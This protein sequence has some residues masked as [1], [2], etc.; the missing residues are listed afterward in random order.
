MGV[1]QSGFNSFVVADIPGLVPGA[2]EGVGLG[3]QFLK[4]LSRVKVLLHIVD[5]S[6]FEAEN[7]IKNINDINAELELFDSDLAQKEQWIV[8]NKNDLDLSKEEMIRKEIKEEFKEQRIFSI[9]A[10]TGKGLKNL[11]SEI[12]TKVFSLD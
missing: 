8:I 6:S 7:I 12:G 5:V 11:V 9:S 2:S 10:I 1:V 4:H 3:I